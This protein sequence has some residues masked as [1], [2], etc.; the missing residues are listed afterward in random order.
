LSALKC[1]Q[2]ALVNFAT[3]T[4]CKRCGTLFSQNVSS[5]SGTNLQG[6]VL[7]DGY[8]LP[9]PPSIG[10]P[11][12]GIWR[13]GKTLVI[14][15]DALLPD[16]CVKCN[17]ITTGRITRKLSWHHSLIY[18]LLLL[19]W[20]IYLVVGLAVR[21]RAKVEFGLCDEDRTKRRTYIW[22]T[23]LMVLGGFAG[24]FVAIAAEDGTPA[25]MGLLLLIT[26]II[27]GLVKARL[28]R[29]MKID[30]RFVWL[31]GVNADYLDQCPPWPGF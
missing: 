21:K 31:R 13:D 18:L 9:P 3:A 15:R 14:S 30:E 22:V 17:A 19:N 4:Q 24:F 27:F 23:W 29:P 20:I 26:A 8:V 28:V 12:A 11:G 16:R 6:F 7:E 10:L 5:E 1:P 2:C 25:L